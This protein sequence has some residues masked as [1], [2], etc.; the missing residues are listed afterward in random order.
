MIGKTLKELTDQTLAWQ[1]EQILSRETQRDKS[2]VHVRPKL[3]V[4][5][6]FNGVRTSP[7]RASGYAL[8]FARVNSYRK[9]KGPEQADTIATIAELHQKRAG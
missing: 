6:A 5:I 7:H 9:D 3:I 4:K 8:R 2:T 1:T